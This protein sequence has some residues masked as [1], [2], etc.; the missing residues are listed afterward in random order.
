MLAAI[1][2]HLRYWR[3]QPGPIKL[4]AGGVVLLTVLNLV[5]VYAVFISPRGIQGFRRLQHQVDTL[6][7]ANR[8]LRRKNAELFGK[9]RK[10]KTDPEFQERRI[11]EQLGWAGEG[12]IVVE[13][14]PND[15]SGESE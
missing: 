1:R 3:A 4:L 12:E 9:V 13:F 11:R 2:K 8:E 15:K 7:K 10:M 14:P 6:E 5:L